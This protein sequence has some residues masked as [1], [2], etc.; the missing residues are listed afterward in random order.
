MNDQYSEFGLFLNQSVGLSDRDA[1]QRPVRMLMF[2][3]EV[4]VHRT[5]EQILCNGG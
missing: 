5:T 4:L 1:G 3:V 2:R